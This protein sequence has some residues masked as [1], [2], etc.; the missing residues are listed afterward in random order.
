MIDDEGL[1]SKSLQ[2]KFVSLAKQTLMSIKP[3]LSFISKKYRYQL[4]V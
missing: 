2:M 1:N 4:I 3:L